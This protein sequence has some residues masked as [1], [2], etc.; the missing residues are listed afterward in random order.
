MV[1]Y[2]N[3]CKYKYDVINFPLFDLVSADARVPR[4]EIERGKEKD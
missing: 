4:R 3:M 2:F 1:N